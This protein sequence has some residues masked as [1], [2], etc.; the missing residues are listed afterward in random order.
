[1]EKASELLH[2]SSYRLER[3]FL[4]SYDVICAKNKVL[5]AEIKE[6]LNH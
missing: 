3:D 6:W 1:M 5:G 4:P 2:A